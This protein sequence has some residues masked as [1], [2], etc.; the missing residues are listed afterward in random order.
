MA[1]A[2]TAVATFSDVEVDRLG[3]ELRALLRS[4]RWRTAEWSVFVVSLD[5]GDTLFAADP[6][7]ERAPASNLKLLTTAAA[8]RELGPT[9]KFRTYLL[10]R[11]PV[12]E[13][14]L[15]GDLVLYGTGDPGISD[16]FF[17]SRG[18][19]FDALI[20]QLLERGVHTVAGDLVGD[21]SFLPGPL[22]PEQW[23]ARDLNDHFAPGVS[24]L[25]FNE[26]VVSVRIEAAANVGEAPLIHTIPDHVDLSVLNRATTGTTRSRVFISR[27]DPMD[28]VLVTGTIQRGGRDVWRQLTVPDPTAFTLSVF[29]AALEGRGIQIQGRTRTVS[30][31]DRSLVGGT[32]VVAPGH[33]RVAPARILATHVSPPLRDYLS[34]VNKKSNNLFAELLFRTLGRTHAGQGDAAA[35]A[36][37]VATSL[38]GLGVDTTGIVQLDGSGLAEGNRVRASTLVGTLAGMADSPDWEVFWES[39]PEAGNRRELPRMYRTAAAGNL[40]A[41]TGTIDRVSALSGVVQS[42]DGERL[43]FSIL[44]NGTPYENGAK[45]VENEIGI[46]LASFHRGVEVPGAPVVAQLPPPPASDDPGGPIRHEVASGESF[47][48]I[49]RRYGVSLESMLAA[50]PGMDPRR[51]RPGTWVVVPPPDGGGSRIPEGR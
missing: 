40:R 8:L 24:A 6:D 38:A 3:N 48:V 30:S 49:A 19:V 42:S 27:D 47:D 10:S 14:T 17:P 33:T 16:R 23:D 12:E 43:A 1:A 28:P 4:A 36:R 35:S 15:Q 51:L 11:A 34:V 21:A 37:A 50:N 25:S 31:P 32:H 39:L 13:G 26:N 9:F 44:V 41:K 46:R 18:T 7:I 45:R 2:P 5:R 29:R 20:D 22:R